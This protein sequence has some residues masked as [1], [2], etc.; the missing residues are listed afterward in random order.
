MAGLLAVVVW[1]SRRFV[2]RQA[3][4]VRERENLSRYFPP[5]VVD[6]FANSD[7]P[8]G[9]V[10]VQP[11]AV[12]FAD[13][14]GFS[15]L[16]ERSKPEQVVETLREFFARLESQIFDHGGTLDKFL[17][18]GLMATFGTPFRGRRDAADA[19]ACAQA[20]L[21]SIARWNGERTQRGLAEIR[22]SIGIHYGDVVLGDIGSERRLEFAV[23]GD[24][25]NV[26]SRIEGLTRR[27]ACR[28]VVSEDVVH[29]VQT[30][31]GEEAGA[32][33]TDFRRGKPQPI[34]GREQT[35]A[36]WTLGSAE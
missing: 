28:A 14:V 23:L 26:A 6:Q 16:A 9:A 17:G 36:I 29:A 19:V 10:R 11:V 20:M 33:L 21:D 31:I 13:I 24:V 3:A 34:R 5:T 22:L 18:D 7:E 4:A 12:M 15:A 25:V 30:E 27:L 35:V 1:R 32:L 8:L 2:I